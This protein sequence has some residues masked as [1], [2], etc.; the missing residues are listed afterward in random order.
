MNAPVG[1][2]KTVLFYMGAIFCAFLS[3][4]SLGGLIVGGSPTSIAFFSFLPMCFLF[5]GFA[6]HDLH[7]RVQAL[8]SRGSD[9]ADRAGGGRASDATPDR[10]RN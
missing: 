7:R 9:R 1:K 10:D 2:S 6:L 5:V 3:L 8:E 4:I